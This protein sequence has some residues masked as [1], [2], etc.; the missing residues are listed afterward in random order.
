L[1]QNK[2]INYFVNFLQI[3]VVASSSSGWN[4]LEHR[5]ELV[6][7]NEGDESR[8]APL[9]PWFPWSCRKVWGK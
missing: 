4:F 3:K 1:A 6:E 2:F 5:L 7:A 8:I 9:E